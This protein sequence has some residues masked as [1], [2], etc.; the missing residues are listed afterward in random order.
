MNPDYILNLFYLDINKL[1]I[2]RVKVFIILLVIFYVPTLQ[3]SMLGVWTIESNKDNGF[4]E[5]GKEHSKKRGIQWKLQF[6]KNRTV[7]NLST[8]AKYGYYLENNILNTYQ[9][10]VTQSDHKYTY[11]T[12]TKIKYKTQLIFVDKIM[13]GMYKG[14]MLVK[15][16]R[17]IFSKYKSNRRYRMCKIQ[18]ESIPVHSSQH[19]YE[20]G[21]FH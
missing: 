2:L 15:I 9:R 12:T 21:I 19:N 14:C 13:T 8:G 5:F 20:E 10:T 3:A 4:V 11:A 17:N 6:L 1:K 18:D 7:I 16:K